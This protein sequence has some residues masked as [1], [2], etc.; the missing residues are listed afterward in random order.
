MWPGLGVGEAISTT[1]IH[2][3]A[4]LIDFGDMVDSATVTDL[5]IAAAYAMTGKHDPLGAAS[6]VVAVHFQT[7][8]AANNYWRD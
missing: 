7:I 2:R 4:G 3:V 6:H 8:A 1:P 5:A